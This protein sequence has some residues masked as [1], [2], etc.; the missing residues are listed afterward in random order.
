MENERREAVLIIQAF[1][2]DVREAR[3]AVGRSIR[4]VLKV[5]KWGAGVHA[6]ECQPASAWDNAYEAPVF[7]LQVTDEEFT[8]LAADIRESFA[9]DW[10]TYGF[11]PVDM[12]HD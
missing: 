11:L 4:R 1:K 6:V 7:R 5:R 9:A 12:Y 3:G 10:P 2:C 8:R